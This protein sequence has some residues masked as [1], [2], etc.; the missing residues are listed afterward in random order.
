MQVRAAGD[1]ALVLDTGPIETG[2][3]KT[4]QDGNGA[5][6]VA[7]LIRAADLP[8]VIDV[9]P[10]AATVLVSVEPGSWDLARLAARLT[11]LARAAAGSQV[12]AAAG[13]ETMDV[14]YDG[15]DLAD[16]ALLTG[17][18]V[19][20]V[21]ARHQAAEYRVGW[22]GFAPGFAYL[23]GL[24]PRLA[25]V[26]RLDSPRQRVPAGS[27]AIA[28]GL[29]AVYPAGSPGGWRL[30]GRTTA[31]LW[32]PD[33]D[34]PALLA[35]GTR[36]RFRAVDSLPARLDRTQLD[37]TRLDQARA[38]QARA[39]RN[40]PDLATP[41]PAA[42]RAAGA[43]RRVEVLQPGPLTTV[44]DLGRAGL[45]HLGVP[46]SG[47]ADIGSLRLANSLVGNEPGAACLE[48]TLGRLALRFDGAAVVAVTGAP[49]PVSVDGDEFAP[50]TAFAVP[51]GSVLRLGAPAA[52]LRSYVA[53]DGGIGVT[54]VLGSRSADCLSGLGPR[55]LRP[56]DW[57]PVERPRSLPIAGRRQRPRAHV[58]A[59]PA[60]GTAELRVIAG[61][62][63]D[64]FGAA[65]LN[66]LAAASF[67]VTPASNRTGLRLAGPALRRVRPGE[68]PS[69]GMAAGSLQVTHE[70]QLILLVAD[71][72]TTGGYPVIAVVVTADLG[73]AAQLRP[74]QQIRFRVS[75]GL[76]WPAA[77]SA[78]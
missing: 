78:G 16:V 57:L 48:V 17:L 38:D 19:A 22:L 54:P 33:R 30:L 49:A 76:A 34:P 1:A 70:G 75:Q 7:A 44:Q 31:R 56:G 9:V 74:G 59:L 77:G 32:E 58:P 23:T 71:R 65:A 60:T 35:P 18:S 45:A 66:A 13:V 3:A 55:P 10:G 72:P 46:A 68:L 29:A 50:A 67:V 43:G 4:D 61:P 12:T 24:D 5:A 42:S 26:P 62:R 47:A 39:D 21:V 41:G 64:W 37:R 14:C 25:A 6:T 51:A 63:D 40:A 36:V 27:V 15:P 53:I 28:G 69:E 11:E 8:G 2:T 73:L 52:G 20:E